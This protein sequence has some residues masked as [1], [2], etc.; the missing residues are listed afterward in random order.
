MI[1]ETMGRRR[2]TSYT[3]ALLHFD[4]NRTDDV[5]NT[6]VNDGTSPYFTVSGKFDGCVY[7]ILDTSNGALSC[8]DQVKDLTLTNGDFTV[9]CWA[10]NYGNTNYPADIFGNGTS[11]G[12]TFRIYTSYGKI[13]VYFY[14]GTY[15]SYTST[16]ALN[17]STWVHVSFVRSGI[18]NYLFMNGILEI[19]ESSSN[20][21]SPSGY[22]QIARVLSAPSSH[23]IYIDELRISS[24][25]RW[26]S[27]FT[28]PTAPYTLD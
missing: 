7:N 8:T 13:I 24:I 25:A 28:P 23:G 21:I 18:N 27:D 2:A 16:S 20:L 12:M 11:A 17:S 3:K 19:F 10:K 1:I 26:T 9:D 15:Y 6:W 22:P 5:G 14:D 4:M